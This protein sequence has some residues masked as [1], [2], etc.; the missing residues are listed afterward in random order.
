MSS[1]NNLLKPKPGAISWAILHPQIRPLLRK[2]RA[3]QDPIPSLFSGQIFLK[4][5]LSPNLRGTNNLNTIK[6]MIPM[7]FLTLL[8]NLL[9]SSVY[10]ISAANPNSH[11]RCSEN[12][13]KRVDKCAAYFATLKSSTQQ[14][15]RLYKL[16]H[17]W[18]IRAAVEKSSRYLVDTRLTMWN[19]DSWTSITFREC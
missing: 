17:W 8:I 6:W 18:Q 12:V 9:L 2:P 1:L 16:S 7:V 13:L 19:A 10:L 3:M 5:R 11:S 14:R 15:P 4:G